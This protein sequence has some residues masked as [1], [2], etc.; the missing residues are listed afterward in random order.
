MRVLLFG[1]RAA[2]IRAEVEKYPSLA[3]TASAPDVVICYG[4]D[5]TLLAAERQWPSIPKVPI[6]HS[7]RGNRCIAH[8]AA[9]VIDRLAGG[10]L[11]RT[12]YMKLNCAV[13]RPGQSEPAHRLL[14]MNE[15]SVHMARINSAVRFRLWLDDESY[16]ADR[17]I[18]GDGFVVSTPFGSTAYFNHITRGFFH[19]GIGIAFKSTS[20]H[21]NH[22]V[23]PETVVVRIVITRGPVLL[24]Y[25]NSTEYVRLDQGDEL[26]V[27]KHADPAVL[28]TWIAMKYPSDAF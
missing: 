13:H 21:T 3:I 18:L 1:E 27:K 10:E 16:G 22:M 11:V 17:E 7:Q 28:L 25:D 23:V 26:V 24:A 14:A 2:D 20:E 6:K 12:Q 4:G 8:P 5:G 19:T 15:V 9:A